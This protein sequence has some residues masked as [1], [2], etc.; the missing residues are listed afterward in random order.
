[1]ATI[2]WS[3]R[4]QHMTYGQNVPAY[5]AQPDGAGPFPTMILL[6][7][8]Y[9]LFQHTLDLAERFASE[10]YVCLAPELFSRVDP[11]LKEA[12]LAGKTSYRSPDSVVRQDLDDGYAF[13][14]D[15]PFVDAARLGLMGVCMSGRYPITVGAYRDDLS[16]LVMFYGGANLR[17]WEVKDTQPEPMAELVP[18]ISAP[19]LG[20]YGEKDPNHPIPHVLHLRDALAEAGKSYEM[21]IYRDMPHG[22][23]NSRMPPRYRPEG[24][25]AAWQQLMGFLQRAFHGGFPRDRVLSHFECDMTPDYDPKKYV[26]V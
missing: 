7:E 12:L 17:E 22:W 14:K 18:R 2:K 3:I 23:L 26:I 10:G 5:L 16:A 15:L 1:M 6:H 21:K 19:V 11:E 9:G 20:V 8:R 24:A 25:E 13:L 4:T